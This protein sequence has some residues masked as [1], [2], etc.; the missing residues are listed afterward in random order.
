MGQNATFEQILEEKMGLAPE[1]SWSAAPFCPVW[2][3]LERPI[4]WIFFNHRVHIP[5]AGLR[6]YPKKSIPSKPDSLSPQREV[7]EKPPTP[8]AESCM[9]HE[10]FSKG[11]QKQIA[12]LIYLGAQ[13]D[14]QAFTASELKQEYRR[15][16]KRYH[17]D[18]NKAQ[19]A[20]PT[21]NQVVSSY[22]GLCL[23]IKG[24]VDPAKP[25]RSKNAR[26]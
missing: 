5:R 10:V 22:R 17:P 13:L 26:N 11:G 9:S 14:P 3:K 23:E 6:A 20:A 4:P 1:N 21:L 16:L 25:M 15:L 7:L 18:H 19:T 12:L 2:P 8:P 24:L